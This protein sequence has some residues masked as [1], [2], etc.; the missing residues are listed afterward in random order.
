MLELNTEQ[1]NTYDRIVDVKL[2]LHREFYP[3]FIAEL[4]TDIRV[5]AVD[6]IGENSG[7]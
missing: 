1:I 6:T 2:A 4:I 5:E 7:Y 3:N